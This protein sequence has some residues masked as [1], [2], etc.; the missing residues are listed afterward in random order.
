M[1]VAQLHVEARSLTKRYGGLTAVADVSFVLRPGEILGCL[2]PNGSGKSTTVGMLVGTIEP[3]RGGVF[4]DGADIR[5][6]LQEYRRHVGYVPEEP[7]LYPFLSGREHV[8]VVG[9]LRAIP[10][11][12]LARKR[13][14]LLELFGLGPVADQAVA[15]YS[16]GMRQRVLLINALLHDPAIILLDEPLSGL[17]VSTASVVRHLMGQL[18]LAGKAILY[19]SHVLEVVEKVCSAAIILN[20]GRVVAHDEVAALSGTHGRRPLGEVFAELVSAD[21]AASVAADIVGVVTEH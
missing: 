7:H 2:G 16:K 3:T 19:S 9:R 1:A 10:E 11:A 6:R 15:S 14:A 21:D 12:V 4:F 20:Q 13:E 5:S 8:E 17:D 18:V